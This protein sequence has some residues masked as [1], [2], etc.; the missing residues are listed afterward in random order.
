[1]TTLSGTMENLLLRLLHVEQVN[2]STDRDVVSVIAAMRTARALE[3]RGLVVIR[4]HVLS[5][6]R[7][8]VHFTSLSTEG[9]KVATS[10]DIKVSA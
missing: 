4:R 9:R 8:V 5:V 7:G 2:R 1:M 3:S 6:G 10:L